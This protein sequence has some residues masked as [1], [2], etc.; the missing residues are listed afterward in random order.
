M[1]TKKSA[2]FLSAGLAMAT[3]G[4]IL[5]SFLLLVWGLFFVVFVLVNSF[6][7]KIAKLAV[8]REISSDKLFEDA[9]ADVTL[10]VENKGSATGELELRD[11]LPRQMYIKYGN[12]YT[13]LALEEGEVVNLRYTFLSPIRGLYE[14]GPVSIRQGDPFGLFYRET[15]LP[16]RD[17]ITIF[18]RIE[19]VRDVAVMSKVPKMYPGA[20]RLRQPGQGSEFYA[21]REYFHGDEFKNIN[22]KAFA[23]SGELMINERE[24]EVV[25]DITIIVDSRAIS[26]AGV[27]SRSPIVLSC[28]VAATLASFF[29]KRR[30]SVGLII[31]ND[32]IQHLRRTS[33][34]RQLYKIL[35]ALA[36]TEAKGKMPLKS[37]VDMVIPYLSL[38]SPVIIISTLEDDA[39]VP[40]AVQEL[41]VRGF[42]VTVISPNPYLFEKEARDVIASHIPRETVVPDEDLTDETLFKDKDV[43]DVLGVEESIEKMV[44]AAFDRETYVV[45]D[46]EKLFYNLRAFGREEQISLLRSYGA[47]VVDWTPEMLIPVM[48]AS[49]RGY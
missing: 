14:I 24:R 42:Y 35:T 10:T 8:K 41:C 44:L 2:V 40:E 4:L 36:C 18:P 30:D 12:N 31:Y 43:D 29:L 21:L 32:D 6:Y 46:H 38:K 48:L 23:R 1:W 13:V 11:T 3:L 34:E 15:H 20:V 22:W 28:R 26:S 37:V 19:H 45:R 17:T 39:T 33:G 49:T 16:I 47:N 5:A 25:S 9:E 27:E 7:M